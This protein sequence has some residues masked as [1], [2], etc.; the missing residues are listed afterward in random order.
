MFSFLSRFACSHE[1]K[2]FKNAPRDLG[3]DSRALKSNRDTQI[4]QK[5]ETRCLDVF[6]KVHGDWS[7]AN[8]SKNMIPIIVDVLDPCKTIEMKS[9]KTFDEQTYFVL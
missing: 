7:M 4:F 3:T 1:S 9:Q 5:H 2:Y 6:A 8:M